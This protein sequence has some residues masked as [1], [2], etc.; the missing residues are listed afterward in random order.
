MLPFI[1]SIVKAATTKQMTMTQDLPRDQS[2]KA[3]L[4]W[5]KFRGCPERLQ[6][7]E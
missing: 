4:C 7:T 3:Q 6:R 1:R 5:A 2:G